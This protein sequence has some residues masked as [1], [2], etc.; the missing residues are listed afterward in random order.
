MTS[1]IARVTLP[2]YSQ[3]FIKLK[4]TKATFTSVRRHVMSKFKNEYDYK[5]LFFE[6]S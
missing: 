1:P 4:Q 3:K 5:G 6:Y 2:S